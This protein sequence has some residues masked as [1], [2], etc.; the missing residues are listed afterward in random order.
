MEEIVTIQGSFFGNDFNKLAITF[1]AARGTVL[2]ATDQLMVA[3]IPSGT[4]YNTIGMTNLSPDL[5]DILNI[6]I[7][8]EFQRNSRI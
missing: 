6:T 1:G 7:P 3:S 5:P 2:L 4:T 8:L